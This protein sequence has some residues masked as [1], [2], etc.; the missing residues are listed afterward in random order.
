L[1]KKGN[2]YRPVRISMIF[3]SMKS[4]PEEEA[5]NVLVD[6]LKSLM[7]AIG[8]PPERI[9]PENDEPKNILRK[10][11]GMPEDQAFS[12]LVKEFREHLSSFGV[13]QSVIRSLRFE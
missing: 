1:G 12:Y 4:M 13:D 2:V 10:A 9:P 6:E 5:L 11:M 3:A 8:I 7:V